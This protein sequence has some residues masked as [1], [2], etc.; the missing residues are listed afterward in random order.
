M[1]RAIER[2]VQ[3]LGYRTSSKTE[4]PVVGNVAQEKRLKFA[5]KHQ[6]VPYMRCMALD[7]KRFRAGVSK[8]K[9]QFMERPGSPLMN[10]PKIRAK[11]AEAPTQKTKVMYCVAA[12]EDKK[13]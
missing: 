6:N 1:L 5:K 7:M 3:K 11:A 8:K 9:K 2:K 10:T 12:T 4:K 13:T